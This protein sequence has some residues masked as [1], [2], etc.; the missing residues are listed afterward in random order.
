[1]RAD[2]QRHLPAADLVPGPEDRRHQ[3]LLDVL[4][5]LAP[6]VLLVVVWSGVVWYSCADRVSANRELVFSVLRN[7]A[8][9]IDYGDPLPPAPTGRSGAPTW[10]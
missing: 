5:V 3:T 2:R 9:G 7:F 6:L 4:Y 8:A 10:C 1:M